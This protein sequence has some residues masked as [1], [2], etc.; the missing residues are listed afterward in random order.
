VGSE[1]CIRDRVAGERLEASRMLARGQLVVADEE[2]PL[3]VVLGEVGPAAGVT[4]ATQRMVLAALAC[5]GVPRISVEE[6][7]WI[8]AETLVAGA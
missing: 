7:L 2:R 4:E 5:K 1:M 3:A 6:A 8:A